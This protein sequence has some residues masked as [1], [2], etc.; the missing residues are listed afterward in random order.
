LRLSSI[1]FNNLRRRKAR[2]L[3]LS[4]GLF[5]GIATVVA[6]LSITNALKADI[7][8][9]LDEFGAN[10]VVAPRSDDLVLSYGGITVSDVSYNQRELDEADA[11]RIRTIKNKE[12]I[13]I[14]APKLLASATIEG[15]KAMVVGVRFHDELRLKK[16]WHLKGEKPTKSDQVMLGS[17]AAE[18][19][20]KKIGDSILISG[21]T[22]VVSAILKE[23][24]SQDDSLIFCD[25]D[26][27]QAMFNKPNKI[28]LIEVAAW[29]YDCPIEEIV[30][31]TASK[32]PNTKVSA[33][34]Q[35]VEAKMNTLSLLSRSFTALSVVVLLVGA[36]IVLVTMMASVNERTREIGIFRAIGF[37][38]SHIMRIILLEAGVV[39]LVAGVLG[40]LLGTL[41]ARL[42]LPQLA[43]TEITVSF[44]PG[45]AGL[46]LAL[47]LTTGIL[48][49]LYPAWRASR[50]DPVLALRSL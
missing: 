28:S 23:T 1:S 4:L 45:L 13:N 14:I 24:G 17:E 3:F 6:L 36:L 26:Q 15:K 19:F 27:A 20:G 22:Y 46:S 9:K 47:S 42:L 30:A 32:L 39:S 44:S 12:S 8:K 29:C 33:I 37:R 48:A 10:I 18:K 34:K 31:Q 16:W 41:A 38:R 40:F 49:S 35:A 43:G 7:D 11:D 21:R 25:L 50:L 5:V 2:T